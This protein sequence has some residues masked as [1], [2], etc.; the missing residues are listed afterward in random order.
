MIKNFYIQEL[1]IFGVIKLY[2]S[3]PVLNN[4]LDDRQYECFLNSGIE[5]RERYY[6]AEWRDS[7]NSLGVNPVIDLNTLLNVERVLN[8][9]FV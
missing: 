9:T 2:N 3:Y 4:K 7:L 6:A 1:L 8:P 5:K